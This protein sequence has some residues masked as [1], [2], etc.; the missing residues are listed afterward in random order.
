MRRKRAFASMHQTVRRGS[1]QFKHFFLNSRRASNFLMLRALCFPIFV[2]LDSYLSKDRRHGLVVGGRIP[3]DDRAN[4]VHAL[5]RA[6]PKTH[7][8]ARPSD[9]VDTMQ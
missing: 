4:S 6:S 5:R 7:R 2:L 9:L 1:P 3:L 8:L